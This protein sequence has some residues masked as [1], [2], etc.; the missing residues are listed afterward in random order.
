MAGENRLMFSRYQTRDA[1]VCP[2]KERLKRSISYCNPRLN[3]N[4]VNPH[5]TSN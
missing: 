1:A 3:F 5:A 4:R 2:L